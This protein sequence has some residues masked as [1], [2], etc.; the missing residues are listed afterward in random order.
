VLLLLK[1]LTEPVLLVSALPPVLPEAKSAVELSTGPVEEPMPVEEEVS[2]S[3]SRRVIHMR[4]VTAFVLSWLTSLISALLCPTPSSW[5]GICRRGPSS[6][7]PPL[8]LPPV[9]LA[10]VE[11]PIG[12]SPPGGRPP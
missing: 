2:L 10:V 3:S 5:P 1:L 4:Y 11:P 6:S 7:L 12:P 9:L 8:P